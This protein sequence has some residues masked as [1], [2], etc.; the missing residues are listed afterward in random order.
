MHI[1]IFNICLLAVCAVAAWRGGGPERWTAAILFVG[2][3][4]TFALPFHRGRTYYS[5]ETNQLAIDLICL[6]AFVAI[7]LAANRYW[8]LWFAGVHLGS[9]AVHGVKGYQ[10]DLLPVLYGLAI[11]KAGYALLFLLLMGAMRHAERRRRY[12]EDRDWSFRGAPR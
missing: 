7:A 10:P 5:V 6:A 3:A 1:V 2:C 9:V 11:S 8:P 12:G 4:A